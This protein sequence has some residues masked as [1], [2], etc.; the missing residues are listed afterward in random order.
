MVTVIGLWL[1]LKSEANSNGRPLLH[2]IKQPSVLLGIWGAVSFAVSLPF[3]KKAV[4][5]SSA[6]L[7]VVL[8]F[9]GVGLGNAIIN[10][11]LNR[12]NQKRSGLDFK[13]HGG[14]LI[15]LPLIHSL[16]SFLV[17]SAL[18]YSLVAYAGSAKRLWSLWAVILS[19]K[20]LKEHNIKRKLLATIIMLAGIAV[21]IFYG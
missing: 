10:L 18:S 3:D 21:T 14:L 2:V 4:V 8:A 5:T 6:L 16:A 15:A 13:S 9:L 12:R 19:G 11:F 1:L 7:T 17:F 20:F